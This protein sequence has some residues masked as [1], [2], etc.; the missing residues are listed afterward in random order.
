M[1]ET[2]EGL[3]D[4]SFFPFVKVHMVLGLMGL[5][6]CRSSMDFAVTFDA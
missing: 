3:T 4:L 6:A 5:L 2:N 1:H